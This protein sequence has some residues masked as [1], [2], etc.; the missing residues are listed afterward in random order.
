MEH[1][2]LRNLVEL[3][4][5]LAAACVLLVLVVAKLALLL[6]DPQV[7]LFMGDSA[8]FL[9]SAI[10]HATPPDRSFTYPM[11]VDQS[12]GRSG[13]LI[14]LLLM[15]S[16]FGIVAAAALYAMLRSAFGV[17][18]WLAAFAAVVL[19]L[20]PS[21]LFYE[22]MILTETTS[23]LCLLICV[24]MTLGYLRTGAFVRLIFCAVFGTV[25]A[26]LRIGM[27]PVAMS[28]APLAPVLVFV[29]RGRPGVPRVAWQR[30]GAHFLAALLV[31]VFC[32]HEY[33]AWYGQRTGS[34]P[35]YLLDSGIFR[36]G[37]V[38]PLVKPEHFA[39]TGV[40]SDV[41][42]EVT[43][44]LADPRQREAHIW[45]PD[46][47]VAVLR[48][49]AGERARDVAAT[50]A[51]RAIADD[52]FGLVRLGLATFGDYFEPW[53]WKQRLRSDLGYGE[54]PDARTEALLRERFHYALGEVASTPTPVATYFER[55]ALWLVVCL[56]ALLPAAVFM[57]VRLWRTRPGPAVLV[58][59]LAAG[60]VAGELLCAHIVSFR[61][62]HP[63]PPL[64]LLCI[65]A[66]L[67]RVLP[68]RVP[69]AALAR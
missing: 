63:L 5:Q 37:L 56:F 8:T 10:S 47:L 33:K 52:P 58:A 3:R 29:L 38:V 12:A 16:A 28:L 59:L 36:L 42:D 34:A 31:T 67:D 23:T 21:Q 13:S 43:R 65:A 54:L 49:H 46:G 53:L 61:Y 50:V 6:W 32:H 4:E 64:F 17:R 19:A 45:A 30:L 40:S 24:W 11:L 9:F 20:D 18:R 22:R 41:L 26:S 15:Q 2:T 39:G 44:P 62:L 51:A 57:L 7:R 66:A 27:V 25:L 48:R 55:G 1:R 68:K 35:T 69:A 60:L 14:S